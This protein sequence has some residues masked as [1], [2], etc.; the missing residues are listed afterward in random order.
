MDDDIYHV[1][2]WRYMISLSTLVDATEA[3]AFPISPDGML[4]AAPAIHIR[5]DGADEALRARAVEQFRKM[6]GPSVE[7]ATDTRC[8]YSV[9]G[10]VGISRYCLVRLVLDDES[11][12]PRVAL[13]F[14][15]RCHDEVDAEKRLESL[16]RVV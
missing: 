6:I 1:L 8:A 13:A 7:A 4:A 15:T 11:T 14:I 3:V 5:P 12:R 2:S 16:R 9:K 10:E